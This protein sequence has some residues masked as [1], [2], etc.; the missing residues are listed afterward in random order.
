MKHNLLT[1]LVMVLAIQAI[2]SQSL[3]LDITLNK[4][5]V[6]AFNLP[7]L[8]SQAQAKGKLIVSGKGP[9]AEGLGQQAASYSTSHPA[10]YIQDF[11]QLGHALS[12]LPLT[13]DQTVDAYAY[14][15]VQNV[16]KIVAS[17]TYYRLQ[18]DQTAKTFSLEAT[19]PVAAGSTCTGFDA[20]SSI[21]V[22]GCLAQDQKTV[23]LYSIKDD[24]LAGDKFTITFAEKQEILGGLRIDLST[25]GD[26]LVVFSDTYRRTDQDPQQVVLYYV[27][28]D[29]DTGALTLS[30]VV[31]SIQTEDKKDLTFDQLN[32][33]YMLASDTLLAYVSGIVTGTDVF[34]LY[35]C[36]VSIDKTTKEASF[37]DCNSL[38]VSKAGVKNGRARY[39]PGLGLPFVL[40]Y[41]SDKGTV[42]QC[43]NNGEEE[44]YSDCVATVRSL[45]FKFDRTDVYVT[46]T[47]YSNNLAATFRDTQSGQ[48]WSIVNILRYQIDDETQAL[49]FDHVIEAMPKAIITLERGQT[50]VFFAE[51]F[52]N[53]GTL[54]GSSWNLQITA[55]DFPEPSGNSDVYNRRLLVK[56]TRDQPTEASI[57]VRVVVLDQMNSWMGFTDNLPDFG[58]LTGG[59]G[60]ANIDRSWFYGN[61][62]SITVQSSA[63]T[64][65]IL[66]DRMNFEFT[67][68]DGVVWTKVFVQNEFR[69][70]AQDATKLYYYT[71]SPGKT[72]NNDCKSE[73]QYLLPAGLQI[74]KV[75]DSTSH[76]D[77]LQGT[78]TIVFLQDQDLK[79]FLYYIY[80]PDFTKSVLIDLKAAVRDLH[81]INVQGTFLIFYAPT[82]G[83]DSKNVVVMSTPNDPAHFAELTAVTAVTPALVGLPSESTY[84]PTNLI[85]CGHNDYVVQFLTGTGYIVKLNIFGAQAADIKL[86]ANVRIVNPQDP[87]FVA[88]GFC[89]MGDEFILWD[90]DYSGI[91]STSTLTDNTAYYFGL[92]T[93]GV[94]R[95]TAVTCAPKS[96]TVGIWAQNNNF[97]KVVAT[98]FGNQ[99]NAAHTKIHSIEMLPVN[100]ASDFTGTFSMTP[101]GIAQVSISD[102][103]TYVKHMILGGP[104]LLYGVQ[105]T[106]SDPTLHFTMTSGNE[107]RKLDYQLNIAQVDKTVKIAEVKKNV[108]LDKGDLNLE[109]AAEIVGHITQATLT[110]VPESLK[111]VITIQQRLVP[112]TTERA[113]APVDYEQVLAYNGQ[114]SLVF[115]TNAAGFLVIDLLQTGSATVSTTTTVTGYS[116]IDGFFDDGQAV[117][118]ILWK[119]G[120]DYFT[121]IYYI[122]FTGGQAT[123]MTSK[124]TNGYL[125]TLRIIRVPGANP[126]Y[127]IF[128]SMKIANIWLVYKATKADSKVVSWDTISNC[129]NLWT[130][131]SNGA[132]L[133][134]FN[135]MRDTQLN[136]Y[137]L[138]DA[139]VA[140]GI[141]QSGIGFSGNNNEIR[142]LSCINYDT[143]TVECA[144][145]TWGPTNLHFKTTLTDKWQVPMTK[146]GAAILY[147]RSLFN[148]AE[149]DDTTGS[150]THA[151]ITRGFVLL[152]SMDRT[153]EL[154][155]TD[156]DAQGYVY[157]R[158]PALSTSAGRLRYSVMHD[159][160]D[161]ER[162]FGVFSD[163][164]A[165]SVVRLN[166]AAANAGGVEAF[167]VQP[168]TL[169]VAAELNDAAASQIV[170]NLGS[171]AQP[172]AFNI[173]DLL[174]PKPPKPPAPEPAPEKKNLTWLWIMLAVVGVAIVVVIGILVANRRKEF[175]AEDDAYN[176][177]EPF[178]EDEDKSLKKRKNSD[179][180][181]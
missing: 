85:S 118:A 132:G 141:V 81:L 83:D 84:A 29:D 136:L 159:T 35:L 128:V 67:H 55:N 163:G 23:D 142:D 150:Y 14:D 57:W 72:N 148:Y 77:T 97:D 131:Q 12:V 157:A 152:K 19:L 71:C 1:L 66:L 76:P 16:L 17:G 52:K 181:N 56:V 143:K 167:S 36:S 10:A 51:S 96:A 149:G 74:V 15:S 146:D 161:E 70:V 41:D 21:A 22:L 133:V 53:Y 103:K 62:L 172:T 40:L 38:Q 5:E 175:G 125:E 9:K 93:R 116:S 46:F 26:E 151:R 3:A 69:L 166:A 127:A 138:Q 44:G 63:L 121:T 111:A 129:F 54:P 162:D 78:T 43:L 48:I 100:S 95:I 179:E 124:L 168:L 155:K 174:Q 98:I 177:N 31:T 75:L 109:D 99:F 80:A 144:I 115:G 20:T 101:S 39:F 110:N 7:S 24:K 178:V 114:R 28:V 34:D 90:K 173:T 50:A 73:H 58:G 68:D 4:D 165:T 137:L 42:S 18:Y 154:Y 164:T 130:V 32:E 87:S 176:K 86:R 170:V 122:P 119:V 158:V 160:L 156:K 107:T 112:A 88:A 65:P 89:P 6:T 169:K 11:G 140:S 153:Y 135:T 30:N 8:F 171:S 117:V 147:S 106:V 123:S 47:A 91:F 49:G 102:N 104:Y 134:F 79:G 45:P 113:N 145:V 60:I 92:E 64:S 27:Q 13:A 2:S 33:V 25:K 126:T 105:T 94:H 108:T 139:T 61:D 120:G 59:Y 82:T 180:F 37:V